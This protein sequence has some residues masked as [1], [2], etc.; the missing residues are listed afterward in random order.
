MKTVRVEAPARLHWGMFDIGGSLERRFGGLGAAI[1]RPAVIVEASAAEKLSAHG[2]DCE[3][4]QMFA[5][6]YLTATGIRKGAHLHVEQAIP[7][8][9]GLGSGTKLA[10]AVAQALATLFEQPT[11]L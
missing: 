6:R 1:A 9:V 11:A 5:Q 4:A 7:S 2:P 8:H 3:R 10:L